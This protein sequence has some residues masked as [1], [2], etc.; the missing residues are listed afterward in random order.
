MRNRPR[1]RRLVLPLAGRISIGYPLLSAELD[2]LDGHSA[3]ST[4]GPSPCRCSR[5]GFSWRA[6][7]R[8]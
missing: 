4:C 3:S 1:N 7:H 6:P 2:M 8:A 5:T